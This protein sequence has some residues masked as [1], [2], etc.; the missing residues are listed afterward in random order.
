MSL[1][2]PRFQRLCFLAS[3][4]VFISG[5]FLLASLRPS[6]FCDLV[7][8]HTLDDF[9]ERF[10]TFRWKHGDDGDDQSEADPNGDSSDEDRIVPYRPID[11]SCHNFPNTSN[12]LLVMKTG[13]S[14]ASKKVPMQ[15]MSNL[16][17]IPEFLIFS[18]LEQEIVGFP[19]HDS[20]DEVLP[21]TKKN[22]GDFDLY[23]RQKQCLIDIDSCNKGY[24][25][26]SQA[27]G[28]D[29]YKNIHIAEKAWRLR[30]EYDW[31][32]YTDA[33]TYVMWATMTEWLKRFDPN[34]RHYIGSVAYVANFPFAHGGSGYLVSRGS[35]KALFDRSTNSSNITDVGSSMGVANKWEE[36]TR[37]W[38]CGDAVFSKAL[39]NETGINVKNA[40]SA[41]AD[42]V[43]ALLLTQP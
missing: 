37:H 23:Q 1:A 15:L 39:N 19:V 32:L 5:I 10:R 20:L 2:K 31:Y 11:P 21:E 6:G 36:E 41:Y 24:D 7:S 25:F 17:C 26:A 14:E 29:K 4:F 38:C 13:A 3:I 43:V 34:K 28:L 12:I 18:D 16:K 33:D 8:C 42:Q 22:N 9:G 35:M 30:P 27:W 40:V